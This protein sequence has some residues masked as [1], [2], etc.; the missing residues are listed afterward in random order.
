MPIALIAFD[1]DPYLRIGDQAIWWQTLALAGALLVVLVLAALIAGRTPVGASA[2]ASAGAPDEHPVGSTAGS[3]GPDD[4]A[5]HLRRDDLLFIVLGIVPGAIL[6]GRLGY[7]ALHLDYY[8]AHPSAIVDPAQGGLQLSVA[9]V[10]GALTGAFIAGQLE[11]PVGRWLHVAIVPVLLG[12]GLGKV[13]MALGGAGQGAA[14]GGE[15][16]TAYLGPWPWGSIAPAIPAYPS[17][18][19]EA[20][21]TALVL[22]VVVIALGARRSRSLDGRIFLVGLALWAVARF[23]VAFTWRD[24]IVLGPLAAD[25][26]ISLAILAGCL[27]LAAVMTRQGRSVEAP[28]TDLGDRSDLDWPDPGERRYVGPT[29]PRPPSDPHSPAG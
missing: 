16:A 11:G 26:L 13:S 14:F 10:A 27:G 18:L 9:I 28:P 20:G 4:E 2:D 15:Y 8:W 29:G 19:I 23:A 3:A 22:V 12:I 24:P 17:Q 1:F 21:L 6:G 25:Q 7:V 5:R